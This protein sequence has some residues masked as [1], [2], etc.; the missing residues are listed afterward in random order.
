MIL[1]LVDVLDGPDLQHLRQWLHANGFK[2]SSMLLVQ[3]SADACDQLA[4]GAGYLG[5]TGHC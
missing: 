1:P 5:V 3:S 2:H 4:A